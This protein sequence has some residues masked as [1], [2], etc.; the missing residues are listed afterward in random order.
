[1]VEFQTKAALGSIWKYYS[2]SAPFLNQIEGDLVN[3]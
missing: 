3:P 2:V 1:M